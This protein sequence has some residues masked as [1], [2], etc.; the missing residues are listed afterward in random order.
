M[1][2]VEQQVDALE[3]REPA[4]HLPAPQGNKRMAEVLDRRGLA[5]DLRRGETA[6]RRDERQRCDGKHRNGAAP[7]DPGPQRAGEQHRTADI[8]K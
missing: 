6:R 1:E 3:Q 8:P 7:A 2:D 4:R 5:V